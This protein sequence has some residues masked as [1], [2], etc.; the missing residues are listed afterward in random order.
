[1]AM[2]KRFPI[3]EVSREDIL[4]SWKKEGGVKLDK[5]CVKKISDK[6]MK[7]IASDMG[8]AIGEGAT[9][10]WA[11]HDSTQEIIEKC[12]IR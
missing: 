6:E 7:R 2:K 12:K 3:A 5:A 4:L 11:I 1:M 9:L 10:W 8:D